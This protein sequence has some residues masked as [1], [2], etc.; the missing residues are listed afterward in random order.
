MIAV[1]NLDFRYGQNDFRLQVPKLV[2]EQGC[3][4]Q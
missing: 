3:P 1:D 2:I 4:S